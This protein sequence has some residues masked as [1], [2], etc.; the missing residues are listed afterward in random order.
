VKKAS[1]LRVQLLFN[2]IIAWKMWIITLCLREQAA[3]SI[4][5]FLSL[6]SSEVAA[7]I[8]S[9]ADLV[10]E[11]SGIKLATIQEHFQ[12]ASENSRAKNTTEK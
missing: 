2:H 9:D 12:S 6:K 8:C 5:I 11:N 10:I 4:W 7:W 3:L 1:N